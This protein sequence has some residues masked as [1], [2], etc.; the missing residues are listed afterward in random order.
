MRVCLELQLCN[1]VEGHPNLRSWINAADTFGLGHELLSSHAQML[2]HFCIVE[3]F[4][5]EEQRNCQHIGLV[6]VF[7]LGRILFEV[8][9]CELL[10]NSFYLLSLSRQPKFF[11]KSSHG[12]IDRLSSEIKELR[13]VRSKHLRLGWFREEFSHL[14]LVQSLGSKQKLCL[15]EGFLIEQAILHAVLNTF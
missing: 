6:L 4:V 5:E 11:E 10:H 7:K 9:L 1:S 2:W 8:C 3:P 13:A 14:E 12:S 15:A